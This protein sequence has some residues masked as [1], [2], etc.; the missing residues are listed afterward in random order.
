MKHLLLFA[1]LGWSTGCS[2]LIHIEC[3]AP[4][5]TAFL[6]DSPPPAQGMPS[7]YQAMVNVPA[8][9]KVPR[10]RRDDHWVYVT[11]PGHAPA[12]VQLSELRL[13]EENR[14]LLTLE[15]TGPGGMLE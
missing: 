13:R 4:S 10:V 15:P 14:V 12:S 3:G 5:A 11:A 9:V 8:T 6:L 2:A 1:I 7:Q